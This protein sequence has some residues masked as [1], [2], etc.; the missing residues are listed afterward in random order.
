MEIHSSSKAAANRQKLK[1][2]LE[3]TH[4]PE[5]SAG[6]PNSGNMIIQGEN[7][8]TLGRLLPSFEGEVKC[9]YI[10]PPYNNREK[11][12]HYHDSKEHLDWIDSLVERV[13]LLAEFL[14]D[15]GSLWI[16]IDDR[17]VHYL[18]VACDKVLGRKNF[19]TTIIWEQ[20]KSR[21]NRKVFS[22]NHEYVLVYAT[23]LKKFAVSRNGLQLSDE[24]RARYKNPDEDSRGPWQ[25]VSA[26]AQGG[27]VR[28]SS[29][30]PLKLRLEKPT[31]PP[32]GDVGYIINAGW[33]L[34]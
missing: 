32:L 1:P 25:S 17:E 15:D 7:L 22:N 34:K 8:E 14:S 31:S 2:A 10:D 16:S 29:F 28:R 24:I 20:R 26:H 23:D 5:L 6:F 12:Y 13:E 18:K 21:E 4:I 11:H 30:I 27:M 19:V 3:L 9:C 33:R